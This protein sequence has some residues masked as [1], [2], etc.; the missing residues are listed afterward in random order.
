MAHETCVHCAAQLTKRQQAYNQLYCSRSCAAAA[1]RDTPRKR[2]DA[3][4]KIVALALEGHPPAVISD[5]L[6][7]PR[8][9]VNYHIGKAR[10]Q[11]IP[12][13]AFPTGGGGHAKRQLDLFE[14]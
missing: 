8:A 11:G 1:K 7:L 9:T 5:K 4:D 14:R 12:I 2:Q 6:H 3:K 13:P 10:E